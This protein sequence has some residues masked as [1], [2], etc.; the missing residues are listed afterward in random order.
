MER[1]GLA[2]ELHKPSH[3]R[4]SRPAKPHHLH[5]PKPRPRPPDPN[6][7]RIPLFLRLPT[8][9]I[10]LHPRPRWKSGP[11][12]PRLA[13]ASRPRLCSWRKRGF[14]GPHPAF[15]LALSPSL[16]VEERGFSPASR[17][18]NEGGFSPGAPAHPSRNT[19]RDHPT[20]PSSPTQSP[21]PVFPRPSS[22]A[23]RVSVVNHDFNFH[24]DIELPLPAPK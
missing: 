22:V 11:L 17:A 3:P 13:S 9:Q 15:N 19:P 24:K 10:A 1:G 4:R 16:L 6:R 8:A 14:L 5:P 21:D 12:G 23:L 2:A 20:L 18:S 7:L